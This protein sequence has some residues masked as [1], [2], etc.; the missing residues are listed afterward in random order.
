MPQ[1]GPDPHRGDLLRRAKAN[2][3]VSGDLAVRDEEQDAELAA[4]SDLSS[5]I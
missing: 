3:A 5:F 1:A 2:A 4:G